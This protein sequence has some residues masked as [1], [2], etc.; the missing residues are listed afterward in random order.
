MRKESWSTVHEGDS[1][2]EQSTDA[3][4]ATSVSNGEAEGGERIPIHVTCTV[5]PLHRDGGECECV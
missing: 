2:D 4:T 5:S 3:A 1:R